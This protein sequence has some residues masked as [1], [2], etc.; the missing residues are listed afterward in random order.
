MFCGDGHLYVMTIL[1]PVRTPL[2]LE[3]VILLKKTTRDRVKITQDLLDH[4]FFYT[5]SV[6]SSLNLKPL[7]CT[8]ILL[9]CF[10]LFLFYMA[11]TKRNWP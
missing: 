8:E 2:N 5:A 3:H 7:C 9:P 1:Y 6:S 4:E 10:S 11:G